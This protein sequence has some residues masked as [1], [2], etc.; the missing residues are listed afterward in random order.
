[1]RVSRA[2]TWGASI[3]AVLAVLLLAGCTG[4]AGEQAGKKEAEKEANKE[5]AKTESEV[6][7]AEMGKPGKIAFSN[8]GDIYTMNP[9]GSGETNL[10]AKELGDDF[11]SFAPAWSPDGKKIAFTSYR[12]YEWNSNVYVMNVDGTGLR[13]LSTRPPAEEHPSWSPDGEK[14]AYTA[15]KGNDHFA[16][17]VMNADGT[18]STVVRKGPIPGFINFWDWSPDGSQV[19]F[20][21]DRSPSGFG[22][23][24]T[25][26]MNPNGT[27]VEQLT[28]APGDDLQATWSPN[29]EKI[30][31]SS[32]REGHGIYTMNPDGTEETRVLKAP[33]ELGELI[34]LDE[35][36]SAWSPDGKKIVWT[37]KYEG[38]TGSKIYV[39]NA[40]GSGLTAIHDELEENPYVDWQPVGR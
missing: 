18:N 10:T 22:Q 20:T 31:F 4:E 14:I 6:A 7:A 23:T 38:G 40:D 16:L 8:N 11:F 12:E 5:C 28:E 25:Y 39:M 35:F 21:E 34:A 27:C 1:M 15:D 26:V 24:D 19:V 30:L 32:D 9:D 33:K 2:K 29:G 36:R 13:R 3:V 17:M 37:V